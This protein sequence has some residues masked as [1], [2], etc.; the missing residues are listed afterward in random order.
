[1]ER[2]EIAVDSTICLVQKISCK[3]IVNVQEMLGNLIFMLPVSC[4]I[5]F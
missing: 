3:V 2:D 4:F 5:S 1:M